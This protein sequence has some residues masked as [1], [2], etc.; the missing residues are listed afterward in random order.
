MRQSNFPDQKALTARDETNSELNQPTWAGSFTAVTYC[1]AWA[2]QGQSKHQAENIPFFLHLPLTPHVLATLIT[3]LVKRVEGSSVPVR[4]R[5]LPMQSCHMDDPD[6]VF[7]LRATCHTSYW[8]DHDHTLSDCFLTRPHS[9][10]TR[11]VAFLMGPNSF[12]WS[13]PGSPWPDQRDLSI[14]T[15][16]LVWEHE[17]M[18]RE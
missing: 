8:G 9:G 15:A 16:G 11:T 2:A 13:I 5:H 12:T 7:F 18:C 14:S 4:S 1:S 10:Q 3:A 6:L 17:G